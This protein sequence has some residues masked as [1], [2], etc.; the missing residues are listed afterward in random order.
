MSSKSKLIINCAATHVSAA[1]FAVSSGKLVMES[2]KVQELQYDYSSQEEWLPA[3][4]A[5]LQM[6]KL[7]GRATLIAP[8]MLILAKTIKIPH[9]EPSRR[10]EVIS[11]E[12]EKNI[13]YPINDVTWDYQ[14]ISDDGVE[15]EIFLTSM[16]ASVADEFCDAV[17]AAGIIPE[18]IEASSILDYNT[19]QY[20]GLPND[21]IILNI[22]ARFTNM[23]VARADGLFV[24]SIPVGG[25]SLTQSLA[26]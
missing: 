1:E 8:S 11:F 7:S 22:G 5:A 16:K 15:S 12:A 6:M 3:L 24:R 23:L 13:P 9:V 4:T 10:A 26:D 2:F 17:S 14:I 18:S 21:V 20:C 25:N 19:W